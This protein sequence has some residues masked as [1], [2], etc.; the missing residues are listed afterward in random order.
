M[1]I[2][3]YDIDQRSQTKNGGSKLSIQPLSNFSAIGL[4]F[5]G[6]G[7]RILVEKV[8]F[9]RGRSPEGA[10]DS[11]LAKGGLKIGQKTLLF[12]TF[13]AEIA[14][15][16]SWS[17]KSIRQKVRVV[18]SRPRNL[19]L[20]GKIST[21]CHFSISKWHPILSYFQTSESHDFCSFWEGRSQ[22]EG[23]FLAFLVIGPLKNL[24]FSILSQKH[25]FFINFRI[26]R[27]F[28]KKVSRKTLESLG[29]EIS[30]KHRKNAFL[31]ILHLSQGAF[32]CKYWNREHE[33]CEISQ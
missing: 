26:F 29:L 9:L 27:H 25:T 8:G 1:L 21:F 30:Q 6:G 16:Y 3:F 24:T 19:R 14:R 5:V 31:H 4:G 7:A 13:W 20:W 2:V 17:Q 23:Y 22:P 15:E 11:K 10:R 28:V 32:S 18:F 12:R 33:K